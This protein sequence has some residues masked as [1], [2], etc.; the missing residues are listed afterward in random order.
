MPNRVGSTSACRGETTGRTLSDLGDTLV[1]CPITEALII[2][3]C[4][5]LARRPPDNV[6]GLGGSLAGVR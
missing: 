2:G 5:D 6:A 1:A 3:P 4:P